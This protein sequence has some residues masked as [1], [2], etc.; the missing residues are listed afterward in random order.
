[1]T[2]IEFANICQN[3]E[4]NLTELQLYQLN[5]YCDLLNEKN[6]VMNLTAITEKEAVYEKHFLDSLL[7][8]F[9]LDFENKKI[10]DVGTGAGFPGLVLAIC[11]PSLQVYL[12]EPLTKRCLFLKEVVNTL[13][14]NNVIII[15]Q[16]CEDYALN[17]REVFDYATARAVKKLNILIEL[18]IPL[19]KVKGIFIALKG[20][21]A[22]QEI[23]EAQNA[24]KLLNCS[25]SKIDEKHLLTDNDQRINVFIIKNQRSL[26]KFPRRYSQIAKKPL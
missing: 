18:I 6:K 5:L 15:N 9:G 19:L 26:N 4:L 16:R 3:N 21:Q 24:F 23:Q 25:V 12:L 8:S 20:P 14:L 10:I 1:M 13:K 17:N 11:Y 22:Y 7:F 2:E